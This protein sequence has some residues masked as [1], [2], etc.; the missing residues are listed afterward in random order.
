M[1]R[2]KELSPAPFHTKLNNRPTQ[3]ADEQT[4]ETCQRGLYP[5]RAAP[6]AAYPPRQLYVLLHDGHAL[7]VDRAQVGVLKQVHEEGLGGLLQRQ[8]RLRLP[9]QLG[10]RGL[11][12]EGDFADLLLVV[13]G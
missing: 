12:L 6:D 11:V 7:G 8:Y 1:Y 2:T 9:A 4:G 3:V 5:P 13:W 10:A